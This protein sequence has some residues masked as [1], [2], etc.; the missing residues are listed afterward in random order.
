MTA[1]ECALYL[2]VSL[3][4]INHL[5]VEREIPYY[6]KGSGSS[7]IYVELPEKTI[8]ASGS[9]PVQRILPVD[10]SD[11]FDETPTEAQLR[12]QAQQYMTETDITAPKVSVTVDMIRLEQTEEYRSLNQLERLALYDTVGVMHADLGINL[13]ARV[14]RLVSDSLRERYLRMEMG[15]PRGSIVDVIAGTDRGGQTA[16]TGTEDPTAPVTSGAFW[17]GDD[18]LLTGADGDYAGRTVTGLTDAEK[19]AIVYTI[20]REMGA[21]Q[22]GSILVAQVLRDT[23]DYYDFGTGGATWQQV[24][25]QNF[26]PAYWTAGSAITDLSV[27]GYAY[28]AFRAVFEQGNS[29]VKKKVF[30]YA[31]TGTDFSAGGLYWWYRVMYYAP[32]L[33][34]DAY[35]WSTDIFGDYVNPASGR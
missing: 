2:G 34:Y 35:F 21:D 22:S 26:S 27:Y 3:D 28:D 9:F 32:C 24:I 33:G 4:R 17:F 5:V 20:Y 30:A 23:F 31:D 12:S 1:D 25:T 8:S 14:S 29:A 13:T 7:L 18:K 6:K 19:G 10:L 16:P 11:R 15:Q